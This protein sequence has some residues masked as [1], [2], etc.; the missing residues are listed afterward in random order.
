[1]IQEEREK[2]M[3]LSLQEKIHHSKDVIKGAI[4]RFDRGRLAITW[5]GGKDSTTML[6]LYREVSN[7]LSIQLPRCIFIDEGDV[8]DEIMEHVERVKNEWLVDVVILRNE[9]VL[10]QAKKLGDI[11]KV[12][13][14]NHGNKQE[15]KFIDFNQEEFPFE[16]ES[17]V[18]NHLMKTVPLKI[19]IEENG[20][21]AVST[22][23]RWDEQEARRKEDYFSS[24]QNPEHIRVHPILHFRERDIWDVIHKYNVPY[25]K[26]YEVGYRSLRAKSSTHKTS[27]IPAWQQALENTSERGGRGQDKEKI[28]AQLRELGYM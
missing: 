5:T 6:W 10:K 17:Y 25:C 19:F 9:D 18:G 26:P 3:I 28:M 16:P 2:L 11:V 14:L 7:E 8:F 24:R 23:I 15:L 4:E 1:M 22:A 13:D 27:N 20:I 21:Q 12:K